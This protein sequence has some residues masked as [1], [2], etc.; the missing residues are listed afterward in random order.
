M[1][2]TKKSLERRTFLRGVGAT[3]A[4][5][6][7]D[8]MVPAAAKSVKAVP[9]LGCIYV[10]NGVF[11][12][13]WLPTAEGA[14]F[15]LPASLRPLAAVRDQVLVLSGLAHHQADPFD[16]DGGSGDHARGSAVWLSGVHAW[17]HK[18]GA[19]VKL[20]TTAD[21]LAAEELGRDTS[22]ASLELTLERS[23]VLACEDGN[24]L[25]SQT[26][27]W[28][29]PTIPLPMEIHPRMV[30]ETLF[31]EGG[32]GA[33]RLA[34]VRE[35][36]SLL[37]SLIQEIASLKKRLGPADQTAVAGYLDAVRDVEQRIQAAE[38]QNA[39]DV[40]LSLPDRPTDV[41][42]SFEDHTQLMFDL[43]TLAY[44]ADITRVVTM[45]MGT[46]ASV[47]TF[48]QI[49]VPEQHHPMSHHRYDPVFI[50]KKC[51]IDTYHVQLLA[52]FIE[53]LRA[54]PDGDGSLLDHVMLLYGSGIGD[55]NLHTHY[56]LPC[57]LAGGGAGTLRSGR[58]LKFAANTPMA[59]LLVTMLDKLG[60]N[61]DRFAD[62]TGRLPIEPL[63]LA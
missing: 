14:D 28:R 26:I 6:F 51:K 22:L 42:E 29:S 36:R 45:L 12:P 5:P 37:D 23:N 21:Q 16:G 10:P 48:P 25:W 1:I 3:M 34:R 54:T 17:T 11:Q 39:S 4:L 19:E 35:E 47:R 46:E 55:G 52:K 61:V 60:V 15:E 27:S 62:S 43:W 56:E 40:A 9:R 38:R 49:G 63:S 41:P 44:Q 2:I 31:G 24:C 33:Q 7:L 20:G 32:S 50:E 53:R 57:L 13:A 58:H 18:K 8:A 59:N 30:F